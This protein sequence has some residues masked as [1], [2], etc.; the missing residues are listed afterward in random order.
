MKN[1]ISVLLSSSKRPIQK[2]I[3]MVKRRLTS[4][5]KFEI[6]APS[7]KSSLVDKAKSYVRLRLRSAD[8]ELSTDLSREPVRPNR[9]LPLLDSSGICAAVSQNP[10]YSCRRL[11]SSGALV[12]SPL[13]TQ[14]NSCNQS[15]SPLLLG[16][17][18][19]ALSVEAN[20]NHLAW[21]SC[22]KSK[23]C[24]N[25]AQTTCL[26]SGEVATPV[27]NLPER[28]LF[29]NRIFA[30]DLK[31]RT[32]FS[33]QTEPTS[34]GLTQTRTASTKI[35]KNAPQTSISDQAEQA[36]LAIS[37][38]LSVT[39]Q[40]DSVPSDSASTT[41]MSLESPATP[42]IGDTALTQLD[43]KAFGAVGDGVTDDSVA[44]Q[45]AELVA[46]AQGR[47]LFFEPGT[48][49]INEKI[50]LHSND[51]LLGCGLN[52]T[53]KM[54]SAL[55]TIF[56]LNG[57]PS[58]LN[59]NI[60]PIKNVSISSIQFDGSASSNLNEGPLVVCYI[61]DGINFLNDG[62]TNTNGIGIL[63]SNTENS[64]INN[65]SFTNIGNK[66]L[67]TGTLGDAAQAIAFCD[68]SIVKSV[69][70]I[71]ENSNFI[72]IGLD[73]I[74][75][76][77]QMSFVASNNLMV[78]L[79]IVPGWDH[80]SAGAA[81]IYLLNNS[82]IVATGNYIE[83]A[84]GNGIDVDNNKNVIISGNTVVASGSGGIVVAHTNNAVI[85]NNISSNNN[86]YHD[87]FASQSGITLI[88]NL[89]QPSSNILI[90]GNR[91]DDTQATA[92][93]NYGL[94]I[95]TGTPTSNIELSG[96]YFSRNIIS[97]TNTSNYVGSNNII[98]SLH[99][100]ITQFVSGTL[101]LADA[102]FMPAATAMNASW[103]LSSSND[104]AFCFSLG[105]NNLT[106]SEQMFSS[107]SVL[108]QG[109]QHRPAF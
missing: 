49:L 37:T 53:L 85:S 94:Q 23:I 88:G 7:D 86:Q 19:H 29:S 81:G 76:S 39:E 108:F 100:E 27:T 15:D 30:A 103:E 104:K 95:V 99:K 64:S 63:L 87:H 109:L 56:A 58:D 82:G 21:S 93:Q 10:D 12:T 54:G 77:D 8:N 61:A 50:Y 89:N 66:T 74:S 42:N 72:A 91:S 97:P 107:Q 80:Y 106:S 65:C 96:N 18:A 16:M 59:G 62:F 102:G 52:T 14:P 83:G 60:S 1:L 68:S 71:V 43:V 17:P 78:G 9:G 55:D 20:P 67:F 32:A 57:S 75:A 92:T 24:V 48:Y 4:W 73:A 35:D 3:T 69:N 13:N 5:L 47:E 41:P 31:A 79:N 36:S 40:K 98:T 84:S 11:P 26:P 44:I 70:N 90:Q 46:S 34:G 51:N 101:S 6:S 22:A 45:N 2:D 38:K 28:H 33:P 105:N 25:P